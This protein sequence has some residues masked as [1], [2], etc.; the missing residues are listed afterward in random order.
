MYQRDLDEK[1]LDR[2]LKDVVEKCVNEV[3]VDVN[4]SSIHLLKYVAGL[5]DSRAKAILDAARTQGGFR[6]RAEIAAVKGIGPVTFR[7]AAGFLRIPSADNPLDM[8]CVHPDQYTT[9]TRI[10][11]MIGF[12]KKHGKL[13]PAHIGSKLIRELFEDVSDWNSIAQTIG[14]DLSEVVDMIYWL[15][16]NSPFSSSDELNLKGVTMHKFRR[17]CDIG[18]PSHLKTATVIAEEKLHENKGI[19]VGSVVFGTVRNIAA[20]GAF[21]DLGTQGRLAMKGLSGAAVEKMKT[22]LLHSSV[23]DLGGLTVGQRIQVIIREIDELRGRV[24][25]APFQ[26]SSST[27]IKST[28]SSGKRKCNDDYKVIVMFLKLIAYL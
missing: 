27:S 15:S 6:S 28:E 14:V 8:T 2:G 10:L 16:F 24:S 21:V 25:L 18:Q 13:M 9:I 22:G 12:T 3:G 5:N 26:G 19:E 23:V 1:L 4:T 17:L 7:N 20:F 11:Q